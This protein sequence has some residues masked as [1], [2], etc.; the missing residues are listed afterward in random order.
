MQSHTEWNTD[1][2]T[3]LEASGETATCGLHERANRNRAY[4][5]CPEQFAVLGRAALRSWLTP[6]VGSHTTVP[7]KPESKAGTGRS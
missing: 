3:K 5:E 2:P 4:S 1:Q 6:A 7:R